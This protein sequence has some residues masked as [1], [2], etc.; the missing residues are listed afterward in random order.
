MKAGNSVMESYPRQCR[1][2]DGKHFVEDVSGIPEWVKKIAKWWSETE[3]SDKDFSLSLE[4]L[5]K[6]DIIIP[7]GIAPNVNSE[8]QLPSWLR[9][10]ARWWSQGILSD[11]EFFKD[12]Q[13]M[14][15]NGFIKT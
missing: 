2:Q 15:N 11:D 5:I 8:P 6:Q 10:N 12:I 1:T 4:Y 13:W 7:R 9:E 14:I 3:I